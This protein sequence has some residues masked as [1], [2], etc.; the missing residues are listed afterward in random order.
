M[1]VRVLPADNRATLSERGLHRIDDDLSEA[2]L[3]AFVAHGL[4]EV[5]AFLRR[6]ADFQTF[7]EER[8]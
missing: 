7:L 6:H 4:D 5:E 3:E 2:W 8:D 1:K